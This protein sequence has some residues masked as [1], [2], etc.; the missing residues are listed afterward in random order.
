VG[1]QVKERGGCAVGHVDDYGGKYAGTQ[2][3]S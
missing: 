3:L 2:R 1:T